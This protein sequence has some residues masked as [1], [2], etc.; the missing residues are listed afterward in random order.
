MVQLHYTEAVSYQAVYR[1]CAKLSNNTVEDECNCYIHQPAYLANIQD[2][3]PL[4]YLRLDMIVT[5]KIDPSRG[6][7]PLRF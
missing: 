4:A 3:N 6:Q 1:A 5:G 7:Q 2:T